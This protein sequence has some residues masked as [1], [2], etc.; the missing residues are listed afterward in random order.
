MSVRLV[1]GN[2]EI[3]DKSA[4][5]I[6]LDAKLTRNWLLAALSHASL[7]GQPPT[8]G[9]RNG[10]CERRLSDEYTKS[11]FVID[12]GRIPNA[13]H[14]PINHSTGDFTMEY[15]GLERIELDPKA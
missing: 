7:V 13:R 8:L 10:T 5:F 11:L 6:K 2:F 12:D 4:Y 9:G 3:A 1:T 15:L 14:I